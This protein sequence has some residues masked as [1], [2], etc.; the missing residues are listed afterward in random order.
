[1]MGKAAKR[2]P[3]GELGGLGKKAL[4]KVCLV[5]LRAFVLE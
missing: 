5:L 1:M 3:L 4:T 2:G